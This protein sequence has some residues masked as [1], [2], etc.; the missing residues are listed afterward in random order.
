VQPG[1]CASLARSAAGGPE[2]RKNGLQ[3]GQW[4]GAQGLADDVRYYGRVILERARKK[5]GHLYPKVHVIQDKDGAWRHAT[6]ED[7]RS[8]K[9]SVREANVIAWLWART[10]ASPN[11]AAKGAH[12]PLVST[13]WLSSKKG[14]LAWLQ[15]VVHPKGNTWRFEVRTGEPPDRNAIRQGTK[16]GRGSFH[17]LLT[18]T[19]IE[20]S[21]LRDQAAQKSLN[22]RL[23]CIVAETGRGRTY[24]NASREHEQAAQVALPHWCPEERVTA[25]CHDVDRLRMYGM[26]TWADPFTLRQLTALVT[27]SDLA[28]EVRQE[29]LKDAREAGLSTKDAEEYARSVLTFLSLALDRSADFNNA[30]CRWT[31]GNQK[32]MNLFG[33]QAIPMAW[34]FAEANVLG[35]S[36]GAWSTCNDYVADC[37]EVIAASARNGGKGRQ[38]DAASAWDDL[39]GVLVSTDPP[40]YANIGYA[41]LSDFFYVW[42]RRTIGD[43][44]PDLFKTILV[45]KE[46]ELVAAPER[47]GGD[48]EKAKEHFETGFRKAFTALREKMDE[49]F[50][51]TVYYAYKQEDEEA[52]ADEDE[53][54]DGRSANG[55]DLTTGWETLLE[56]L[57]GSGFQITAT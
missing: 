42:L 4:R 43:L 53:A 10:V 23:V 52:G 48:R 18:D 44:Y 15:P 51:L 31:A 32:V 54:A 46:P 55:V 24:L 40:Y 19:P 3:K 50:P 16:L 22:K 17:C 11:P 13:F 20:Y 35:D 30:L 28:R 1:A 41:A 47:F 21:H 39:R 49:R 5:I 37:I 25:P 34:D 6:P 45:P 29:A 2:V 38:I 36:V 26:P 27:L 56:A 12:V 33:K 14:T 7:V 8:G 9:R 57:L